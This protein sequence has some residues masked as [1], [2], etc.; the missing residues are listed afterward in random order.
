MLF[1][2]RHFII[3][4]SILYLSGC[5]VWNSP[6][7]ADNYD[8]KILYSSFSSSP[9]HLD[10]ARS[11]SSDEYIL[12]ENIYEPPLQYHYLKRP[13]QLI[14]LT[15]KSIPQVRIEKTTKQT[16]YVYDI[17]LKEPIFYAPHPAFGQQKRQL[18]AKDYV[19]QIKRLADSNNH[20]PIASIMAKY[21][22][23]FAEYRTTLRK[24]PLTLEQK[25]TLAMT[26]LK[27]IS[28][29]H[30]QIRLKRPY[31][32]FKYWLAMPFFA[33]MPFEV[34]AW[35]EQQKEKDPNH[36]GIDWHPIGTGPFMMTENNPNYR[37][38]LK[39][40]PNFHQ[41]YF[42]EF[43]SDY[44]QQL[45]EDTS[46][47][48][49]QKLPLLDEIIYTLEKESV[50]YWQ[51]FLQG[52]YDASGVASDNFDQAITLS[53]QGNFSL[54]QEFLNKKIQLRSLIATSIYYYGFNMLSDKVGG[55]SEAQKKLRQAISIALDYEEYIAVFANSRGIVAQGPIAPG[56][57]GYLE[58]KEGI[59]PWVYDWQENKAQ[60]KSIAYAKQLLAQA[61]Y[62]NGIDP[63]TNE[64]LAIHYEAVGSAGNSRERLEWLRRQL[65]K[66]DI[67]VNIRLTDYNR[68][69]E[70]I[71]T[72]KAELFGWGWN[73]DYPDP[74]NFLFLLYG[75]NGKVKHKG[76]NASNY[77]NPEYD[78][79]YEQM[80]LMPNNAERLAIIQ[81]MVNIARADSPWIWGWHPMAVGLY[82]QW[83]DNAIPNS[84][85]KNTLKY[86]A[87]DAPL[88]QKNIQQWNQP[89]LLPLILLFL[90]LSCA[91]IATF[92]TIK[93]RQHK[94]I[95]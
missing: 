29:H 69:R 75:P 37:M 53:N 41:Q 18:H 74:E 1:S 39:K 30:Y 80:V 71:N 64:Q 92:I 34:I 4:S 89:N 83:V 42:P 84:V 52:Y 86:R 66:I 14:P 40:N 70:K 57:F 60:R 17:H 24:Q 3:I 59:N 28:P 63:K 62:E 50:P 23:G 65:A 87:V 56:I 90:L 11:Y 8:K 48:S 46:K 94:S 81:K 68:F 93:K 19:F 2:K 79:L 26:G 33:P 77:A 61:G 38:V 49:G 43:N 15:A 76:E 73:A 72:G 10:P 58:G 91:I 47:Y 5:E 45:P 54:S 95:K 78:K 13:Y 85:S 82:H 25:N 12:I 6:Y 9:K 32:Q 16:F 35:H 31:P 20:S 44:L 27:V 51:K 22:A 21:I 67:K 55:Y 88:R 36:L 7:N